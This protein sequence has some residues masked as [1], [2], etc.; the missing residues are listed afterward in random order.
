MLRF[1]LAVICT[2][3]AIIVLGGLALLDAVAAASLDKANALGLAIHANEVDAPEPPP[4]RPAREL[5]FHPVAQRIKYLHDRLRIT[6]AQEPLWENVAQ[7][8]RE[9][10]DAVAPLI[11]ERLESAQHGSAIDTLSAYRK[12]GA[13]QLEGLD[14]FI[15]AFQALYGGLS[16]AQKRIADGLFRLGPMSMIGSIPQL[17]EQMVAPPTIVAF[18]LLPS[19]PSYSTSPIYPPYPT[20]PPWAFYSPF[21]YGSYEGPW[22]WGTPIAVG[23]SF[24][25]LHRHSHHHAFHH[26]SAPFRSPSGKLSGAPHH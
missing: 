19:Y 11:A 13:A 14:K 10:A 25:F 7:A 2:L 9:N 12:L 20:Y 21:F 18:P 4:E 1:A 24:I 6:P 15:A 26:P 8:M 16:D 3:A 17:A 22:S 5:P 23:P